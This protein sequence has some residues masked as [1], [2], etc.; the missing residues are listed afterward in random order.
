MEDQSPSKARGVFTSDLMGSWIG[1]S[2]PYFPRD[3]DMRRVISRQN[4]T[5]LLV[6]TSVTFNNVVLGELQLLIGEFSS[7]GYICIPHAVPGLLADHLVTPLISWCLHF[8]SMV[9]WSQMT[10]SRGGPTIS[11]SSW[12]P[13]LKRDKLLLEWAPV[14]LSF[15]LQR[16]HR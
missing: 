8:S 15:Y 16:K 3:Q 14:S 12:R 1:V 2:I 10:A 11:T 5:F 4:L 6:W 13:T 9:T 7:W